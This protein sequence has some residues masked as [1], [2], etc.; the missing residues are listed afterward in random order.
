MSKAEELDPKQ[1][2]EEYYIQFDFTS[3]L[4]AESVS[5][6]V[7]TITDMSDNSDVTGDLHDVNKLTYGTKVV[8]VWL[9]GGNNLHNYH[10]T[11]LMTGASGSIYELDAIQPVEDK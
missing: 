11:C 10:I 5:S 1:P 9:R 4:G 3:F 7:V 8:N 2:N 6:A